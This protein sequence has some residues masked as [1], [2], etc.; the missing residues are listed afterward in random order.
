MPLARAFS[1]SSI[2]LAAAAFGGLT[3]AADLSVW[4]LSLGWT[5]LALCLAQTVVPPPRAPWLAALRLS[6]VTWNILLVI[7]FAAFWIDFLWVSQELL[8]AGIHFLIILMVNK[9]FNL[10]QRRD[11]LHLYAVSLMAVLASAAMTA[12]IWYAPFLLAYLCAG[13]WTLLLYHLTKERDDM[14]ALTS[15]FAGTARQQIE[16]ITGRFFWTTNVMVAGAV[17]LTI[18]IFFIIPRVG[19]G[20]V[21]KGIGD[22]LRTSGFTE[23][24]DLGMM[25]SV[26]QDPSIVMRVELAEGAPQTNGPLYLRG[27]TYDRYNGTSW[28]NN[29]INRR[30]LT[31]KPQGLFT[32]RADAGRSPIPASQ[33]VEQ[34][35]LLEALDISVLF[36]VP[37][38]LTIA[39]DFVTVQSDAAGVLYVPFPSSGRIQY[40]VRSRAPL[41][42]PTDVATAGLHYP[43]FIQRQY[44]QLP[45]LSPAIAR[46]AQDVIRS[47]R[48]PHESVLLIKRHLL[49]NYRYSLDMES[50]RSP[51]PLEDFLFTRKTGYCEHYASAMVVML[52]SIGIPARLVT[53]F[54][55]SEW[56]QFGRYYTVRQRDA[57]A[58]V[59]VYFPNSGWITFDP[60]PAQAADP[61]VRWWQSL[62]SA[63]DSMRL[64]WDQFIIQY[65]A[66]DQLAVIQGV[67]EGGEALRSRFADGLA[68]RLK[69]LMNSIREGVSKVAHA[70]PGQ[71]MVM[72]LLIGGGLLLLAGIVRTF[73]A[74]RS[75][76]GPHSTEQ[77]IAAQWYA[78]MLRLTAARGLHKA[79][80]H[81]PLEFARHVEEQWKEGSPHIRRLTQLYCRVRFGQ[82][83][84]SREDLEAAEG[85]LEALRTGKNNHP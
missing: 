17:C 42:H 25:G 77:M 28:T 16:H 61:A 54:L 40:R 70:G 31:E 22:N 69:S 18:G 5:A 79:P 48:T 34:H 62:D 49:E 68:T 3:L 66:A 58:W 85:S 23:K 2:L 78:R 32:A 51:H 10:H 72:I 47:G 57:H 24:V 64:R 37:Q 9:L 43:E 73:G 21:Q 71:S 7:A 4:M 55:A 12:H 81:T 52:R 38:A 46:L 8:P 27:M 35:I 33:E 30:S 63:M 82:T 67:R 80:A 83:A 36:A 11:F 84:I 74:V 41:I 60:T 26:K 15:R 6:S 53:G 19:I 45:A 1:L 59:E 65:N 39:G 76:L 75:R 44:L 56:N 20:F 50:G 13:V 29:L 14:A